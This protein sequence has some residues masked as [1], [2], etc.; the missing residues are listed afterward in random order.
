MKHRTGAAR[1]KVLDTTA[2]WFGVTYAADRQ[3]V[4]DSIR[5]LVAADEYPK[6][7]W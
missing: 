3:N 5:A 7:L 1:V 4:V 2:R 6:R